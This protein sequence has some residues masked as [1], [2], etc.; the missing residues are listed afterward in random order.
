MALV[1]IKPGLQFGDSVKMRQR[2]R[3]GQTSRAEKNQD[4]RDFAK[5]LHYKKSTTVPRREP[6]LN[7]TRKDVSHRS[8]QPNRCLHRD[9]WSNERREYQRQSVP[10]GQRKPGHRRKQRRHWGR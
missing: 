1:G 5:K 7:G 10:C 6:E 2:R 8:L 4:Y 3:G 9:G